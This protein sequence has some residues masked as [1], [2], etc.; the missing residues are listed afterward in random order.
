MP[1]D[2]RDNPED[3]WPLVLCGPDFYDFLNVIHERDP[4]AN[5][6]FSSAALHVLIDM[7]IIVTS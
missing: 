1:I 7:G 3:M 5:I 6:H 4:D 2:R